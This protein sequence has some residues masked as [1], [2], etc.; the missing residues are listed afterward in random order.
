MLGRILGDALHSR[1][2]TFSLCD[3]K[4]WLPPYAAAFLSDLLYLQV[5]HAFPNI[6]SWN[7]DGWE[8]NNPHLAYDLSRQI[9]RIVLQCS[10]VV[11]SA[12]AMPSCISNA[13]LS[14]LFESTSVRGGYVIDELHSST[15]SIRA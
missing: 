8:G 5:V 2:G 7:L 11:R 12:L 1:S 6:P 15:I 13:V 4:A 14:F 9:K 10:F 3:A